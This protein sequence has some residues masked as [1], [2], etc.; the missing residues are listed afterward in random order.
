MKKL[1]FLDKY[2]TSRI[3]LKNAM[4]FQKQYMKGKYLCI[5]KK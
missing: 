4:N 5:I 3:V 1:Y 2:L